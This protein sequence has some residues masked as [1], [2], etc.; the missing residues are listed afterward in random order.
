MQIHEFLSSK[1]KNNITQV[2]LLIETIIIFG[3]FQ[4]LTHGTFLTSRNL[5]NIMMQG[6]VYSIMGIG[7]VFVMVSG[8]MDLSGGSV[9]GLLAAL[10]AVMQV[11]GCGTIVTILA[12]LA[13]G[14]VI[15]AWQGYWVSYRNLPSFIVTLAGM[16]MFRGL[17]LW[18][19]G[20]ATVGPVSKSFGMIG[21]A[22]LPTIF[23]DSI[24]DTTLILILL[25]ALLIVILMVRSRKNA[26]KFSL[27]MESN[28]KFIAKVV[29]IIAALLLVYLILNS[30][31]GLPYALL[32]LAVL[33]CVF[34]YVAKNTVF[35]R[36]IFSIG[37]NSEATRLAGINVKKVV[38]QVYIL[39]GFLVAIASIVYLGRVGQA[40]ASAGKDFEFSAI[41][42]CIVGGVSTLGGIGSIP[43]AILGTIL[44]TG[45]DNG[46][47][48]MNLGSMHQY[49]VRGLVLLFAVAIDVASKSK[50]S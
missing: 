26:R 37:G 19:G 50:N 39:M 41:T 24:H 42:G 6:C 10:G 49:I 45:L 5:T 9:L 28:G 34:S 14:V 4:I 25:A 7:I 8:N 23:S 36:Y 44:M 32:L 38:F 29:A 43:Y 1:V 30:Y 18:V 16:L 20:G 33:G 12:M 48:L 47:S 31:Q 17:C 11:N 35:G 15:G 21:A 40:T 13:G 46:M 3:V 22:Y 2:M 27:P